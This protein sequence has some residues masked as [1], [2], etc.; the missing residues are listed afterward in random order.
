MLFD[1]DY[2]SYTHIEGVVNLLVGKLCLLLHNAENSGHLVGLCIDY[3]A[4]ALGENAGNIFYKPAARN[5]R[6]A[7]YVHVLYQL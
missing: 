1:A 5:V 7:L 3:A 2:H 4:H 6:N